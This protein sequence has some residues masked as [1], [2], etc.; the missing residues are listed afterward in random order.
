[1]R[2]VTQ[3]LLQCV[4]VDPLHGP[5]MLPCEFLYPP[6]P[7]VI[8][9]LRQTNGNNALRVPLEHHAYCVQA[10]DRLC[11]LHASSANSR[12][13]SPSMGFTAV[14]TTRTWVPIRK[15]RFFRLPTHA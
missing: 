8:A 7:R 6:N 10:V 12:S 14:T 2:D 3:H 5:R 13:T 9:A 15:R 4:R 11:A 1:M